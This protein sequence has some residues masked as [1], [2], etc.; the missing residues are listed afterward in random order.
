MI[1]DNYLDLDQK[2]IVPFIDVTG[3]MPWGYRVVYSLKKQPH[4]FLHMWVQN[5]KEGYFVYFAIVWKEEIGIRFDI[6]PSEPF[7]KVF[8]MEKYGRATKKAFTLQVLRQVV[9]LRIWYGFCYRMC[10]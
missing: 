9:L 5:E 3:N 6:G 2:D 10:R 7:L 4:C 1:Y 8:L